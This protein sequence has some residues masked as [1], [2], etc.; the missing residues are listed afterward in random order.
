MYFGTFTAALPSSRMAGGRLS[1]F[2]IA[3]WLIIASGASRKTLSIVCYRT[4]GS[5]VQIFDPVTEKFSTFNIAN[6]GITSNFINSIFLLNNHEA[7]IGHSQYISVFDLHSRKMTNINSTRTELLSRV[8]LSI[9][10]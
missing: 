4:L 2:P 10:R 7:L 9:M 1:I 5:G 6:S 8:L 3:D